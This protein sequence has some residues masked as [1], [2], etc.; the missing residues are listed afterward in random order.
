VGKREEQ[1]GRNGRRR[2]TTMNFGTCVA[3]SDR[4]SW[5]LI[6]AALEGGIW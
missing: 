5:D 1:G 6:N 4:G 2:Q 3:S